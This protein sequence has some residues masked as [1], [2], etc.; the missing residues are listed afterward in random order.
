MLRAAR[1]V[2]FYQIERVYFSDD[3]LVVVPSAVAEVIASM[4]EQCTSARKL[5]FRGLAR[6]RVKIFEQLQAQVS[7]LESV[8]ELIIITSLSYQL[9]SLERPKD[10]AV[11]QLSLND[12]QL[13]QTLALGLAPGLRVLKVLFSERCFKYFIDDSQY[14]CDCEGIS[15]GKHYEHVLPHCRQICFQRGIHFYVGKTCE[16]SY[17]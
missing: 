12:A 17:M 10:L 2:E 15:F 14:L 9:G 8:E 1:Q 13:S 3:P 7:V 4:L 5:V 11:P 6:L 16:H